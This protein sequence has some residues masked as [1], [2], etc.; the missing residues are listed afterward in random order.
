MTEKRTVIFGGSFNPIHIG[1]TSL[2][3]EVLKQGLGDEVWF[4]VTPQNPHKQNDKLL[5]E[6]IRLKMVQMAV[7]DE[8][9]FKASGFEF[10]LPRPSYTINT[11]KAL[12]GKYPDRRFILLVGADN[13][14]KFDMWNCGEEILSRYSLIVYPRDNAVRPTLPR[15]VVWLPSELYDVSSTVI[16]DAIAAGKD[17]S[18]YVLPSV[19]EFINKNELYK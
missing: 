5:D 14:E 18:K 8:P 1:H 6:N 19:A 10:S 17:I 4:M 16:R 12:E 13:W 7:A 11:L 3:R 15:N 9:R 2:A